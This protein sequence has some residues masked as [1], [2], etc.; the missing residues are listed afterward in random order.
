MNSRWTARIVGI[1]MLIAFLLLRA[2][3]QTRLVEIERARRANS[4][5]STTSTR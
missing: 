2:H 4:T 5:T 3:L 1:I